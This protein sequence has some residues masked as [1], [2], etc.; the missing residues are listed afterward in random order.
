MTPCDFSDTGYSNLMKQCNPKM[1]SM[2]PATWRNT[3]NL[4]LGQLA[5]RDAAPPRPMGPGLRPKGTS[6]NQGMWVVDE[7]PNW[8]LEYTQVTRNHIKLRTTEF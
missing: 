1:E 8:D 4:L 7:F 5:A 6:L 2:G 3:M